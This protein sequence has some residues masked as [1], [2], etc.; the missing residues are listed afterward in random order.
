M[1]VGSGGGSAPPPSYEYG[2]AAPPSF[3]HSAPPG[4][5]PAAGGGGIGP[6][7]SG[8]PAVFAAASSAVHAPYAA[9][10]GGGGR[11]ELTLCEFSGIRNVEHLGKQ[12]PFAKIF[13]GAYEVAKTRVLENAGTSGAFNQ[14]FVIPCNIDADVLTIVFLDRGMAMVEGGAARAVLGMFSSKAKKAMRDTEIG[15]MELRLSELRFAAA[16][17]RCY[18]LSG[19]PGSMVRV[20]APG[21]A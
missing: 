17:D 3:T 2:H 6:Y 10:G 1:P 12:D 4:Y 19:S 18:A 20:R 7:V 14:A 9:M 8:S 11:V 15:R 5:Y 21:G 16:I 13:V